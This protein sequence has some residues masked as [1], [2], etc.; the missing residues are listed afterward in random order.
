LSKP[1]QQ[2]APAKKKKARSRAEL[3]ELSASSARLKNRKCP[4]CGSIM[5][6][7]SQPVQRWVCGSCSFT[8]YGQ[9]P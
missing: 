3:Y 4:R 8:D 7:H 6:S 2:Q 1:Q 5:A 9:K